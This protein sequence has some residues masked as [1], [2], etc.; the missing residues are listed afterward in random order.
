LTSIALGIPHTP[1]IEERAASMARVKEAL[2]LILD[3]DAFSSPGMGGL[4]YFQ[5]FQEPEPKKKPMI[6]PRKMWTWGLE[7]G[8]D[9]FLTLQDD[10]LYP[11]YFWNALKAMLP[12]VGPNQ[13]LSLAA[14][15]PIGPEIARQ[16]HRWYRTNSWVIGWG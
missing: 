2:R 5:M 3:R 13:V 12:H 16:G 1:W 11:A 7:T 10:T 4:E 14:T 15:H 9:W 6:W 8:A